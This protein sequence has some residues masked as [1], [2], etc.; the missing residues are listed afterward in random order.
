MRKAALPIILAMIASLVAVPATW[1]G[2]EK[3]A[4]LT[5]QCQA[6]VKQDPTSDAAKLCQEGIQLQEQGKT[7][8]AVAKMKEGLAKAQPAK[9]PKKM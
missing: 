9:A 2:G 4:D 3:A 8:E 7:D 1:A 5:K 6:T